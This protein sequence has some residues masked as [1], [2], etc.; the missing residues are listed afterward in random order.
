MYAAEAYR[1]PVV[2]LLLEQGADVNARDRRG[3]TA[4]HLA[5]AGPEDRSALRLAWEEEARAVVHALVAGGAALDRKDSK[6][7]TP[8]ALARATGNHRMAALLRRLEAGRSS[9]AP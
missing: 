6:G 2:K 8:Q 1:P 5:A 7:L 9:D 3:R 4:L